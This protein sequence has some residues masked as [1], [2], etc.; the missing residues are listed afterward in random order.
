MG[1]KV[2]PNAYPD[3]S[4]Y[5]EIT[6]PEHYARY[7]IEPKEFILRNNLDFPTGNVIK[8]VMRHHYKNGKQDLEKAKE[9]IDWLIKHHY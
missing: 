1:T 9:Y 4:F 2:K 3:S 8:Y 6:T 7:E 5:D